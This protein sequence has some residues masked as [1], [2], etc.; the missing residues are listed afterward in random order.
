MEVLRPFQ[1]WT[2]WISKRFTVTLHHVIAVYND[3]FDHMDGMMHALAKKKTPW[4]EDL[5]F[6]VKLARQK[7]SEY[8]AE[9][10]PTM[11]ILLISAPILDPFWKLRLFGK[12]DKGMVI[13]PEDVTSYT[14]HYQEAFLKYVENEY[15]AK[16]RGVPVIKRESLPSSNLIPYSMVPGSFQSL[17]NPY[18]LASN[19][20][21]YLTLNDVVETTPRRSDG[22][23]HLITATRLCSNSPPDA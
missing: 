2:L 7:L 19:D 12:W 9:V 13:N 22:A 1:Y 8:Y 18:D 11:G 20:D 4:K 10:T 3:M 14:T 6:T 21:E 23:A 17:F 15:C 16:H 5:F